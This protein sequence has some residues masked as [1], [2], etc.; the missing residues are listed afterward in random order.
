MLD[1]VTPQSVLGP[2][3]LAVWEKAFSPLHPPA[4]LR[5]LAEE[6]AAKAKAAGGG[7][8][9][10]GAALCFTG[11]PAGGAGAPGCRAAVQRPCCTVPL[12]PA[13]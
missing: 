4:L 1:Q 12:L 13:T 9:P 5:T 6:A 3:Y 2:T 10:P 7:Q 11:K 8:L